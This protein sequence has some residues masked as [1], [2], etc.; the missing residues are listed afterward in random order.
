MPWDKQW[1]KWLLSFATTVTR[2]NDSHSPSH[3]KV[4][5]VAIVSLGHKSSLSLSL[6][7]AR[8]QSR[9]GESMIA[10]KMLYDD[11]Q[12][13]EDK[14][15]F[16]S[17]EQIK[18]RERREWAR[19]QV[20][21]AEATQVIWHNEQRERERERSNTWKDKLSPSISRSLSLSLSLRVRSS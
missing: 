20:T 8:R 19:A 2:P 13:V 16:Y 15:T 3:L 12:W 1:V 4:L 17:E 5:C 9:T 6:S 11:S 14:L 10:C 18:Q 7:C 21:E